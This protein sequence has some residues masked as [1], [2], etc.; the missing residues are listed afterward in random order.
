MQNDKYKKFLLLYL[1]PTEQG[2]CLNRPRLDSSPPLACLGLNLLFT[3]SS[4]VLLADQENVV[5]VTVSTVVLIFWNS[6][7]KHFLGLLINYVIIFGICW[8]C[9]YPWRIQEWG[10]SRLQNQ[11]CKFLEHAKIFSYHTKIFDAN[12]IVFSNTFGMKCCIKKWVL[13]KMAKILGLQ[14]IFLIMQKFLHDA[15]KITFCSP[16]RPG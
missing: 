8:Q 12:L 7:K 4:D 14:K 16:E 9:T 5:K 2:E 1:Y 10:F 13:T 3:F 6:Y 11:G 15:A